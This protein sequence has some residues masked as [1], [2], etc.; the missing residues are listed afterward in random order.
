MNTYPAQSGDRLDQIAYQEYS[1]LDHF[2]KVIEANPHLVKKPLLEDND[3]V[4]LPELEQPKQEIK[5]KTLW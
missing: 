4:N 1:T 2:D 5:V 3:I